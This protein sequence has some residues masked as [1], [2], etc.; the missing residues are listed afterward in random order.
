MNKILFFIA[1]KPSF[2]DVQFGPFQLLHESKGR[3]PCNPSAAPRPTFQW[4]RSGVLIS[5]GDSSRY[6]L[7]Q[8]GTLIIKKVDKDMDAVNYTCSA[9]NFLGSD[10]ATAVTIVLGKIFCMLFC[11]HYY[12]YIIIILDNSITTIFIIY[13]SSSPSFVA[14]VI[15]RDLTI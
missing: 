5:Y 10:F 7:E 6:E 1:W 14:V 12:L 2:S 8:D 15:I 11:F 13:Q 9:K 4:F 3:L